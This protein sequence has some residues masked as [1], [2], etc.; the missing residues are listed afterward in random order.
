M[1]LTRFFGETVVW[2]GWK[3]TN[4]LQNN[5]RNFFQLFS[6][7]FF[8]LVFFKLIQVNCSHQVLIQFIFKKNFC[9][10]LSWWILNVDCKIVID[11][12]LIS[13][14]R[15]I[16]WCFANVLRFFCFIKKI[17]R[18]NFLNKFLFKYL[19]ELIYFVYKQ[20]NSGKTVGQNFFYW[21][22]VLRQW[23]NKISCFLSVSVK[24]VYRS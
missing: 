5:I 19:L 1:A 23:S 4:E 10:I 14:I 15:S 20:K 22:I 16:F 3:S 17:L 18:W 24:K 2:V 9:L 13:N 12:E 7:C 21:K 8:F 6:S 11:I